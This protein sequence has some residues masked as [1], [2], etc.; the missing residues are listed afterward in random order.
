MKVARL[1]LHLVQCKGKEGN[2]TQK[3]TQ[4]ILGRVGRLEFEVLYEARG[5]LSRSLTQLCN[6]LDR[7]LHGKTTG[8]D[9]L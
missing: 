4:S 5:N 9:Q 8:D 3:E 1:K 7:D 6:T 2:L